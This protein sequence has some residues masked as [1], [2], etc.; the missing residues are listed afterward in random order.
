MKQ[1]EIFAYL[2]DFT[3]LL[4]DKTGNINN[5]ILFG[6]VASGNFDEKSD[7][8][9]FIDL[10]SKADIKDIQK[11]ID[12]ALNE[13]EEI[14]L[15]KWALRGINLPINCIVGTLDSK[16]WSGLK[17]E[18]ISNGITVF[19]R[20]KELPEKLRHNM[21][22][23]FRLSH[24]EP[25]N[26]VKVLRQLYGYKTK[27]QKKVY[28]NEGLLDAVGGLKLNPS[29]IM[30]PLAHYKMIYDF[31]GKNKVEFRVREIWTG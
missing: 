31:F 7:V 3:S 27:K 5:I 17:R 30:V 26:K 11:I 9:L 12:N 1:N 13:F 16:R 19:G 15:K 4:L 24:L 18:I 22:F 29:T 2:Y 25:K 14:V 23:S 6:S 21:L 8:D 10:P 20:Y 28:T